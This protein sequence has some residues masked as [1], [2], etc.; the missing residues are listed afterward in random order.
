M[1]TDISEA[2]HVLPQRDWSF[3]AVLCLFVAPIWATVPLSWSYVLHVLLY[4]QALPSS[5]LCTTLFVIALCEVCRVQNEKKTV[6]K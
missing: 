2:P 6:A 4:R 3:Y 5:R 1:S